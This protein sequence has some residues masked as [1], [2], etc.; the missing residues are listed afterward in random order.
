MAGN[1]VK[2]IDGTRLRHGILF[3]RSIWSSRR[4]CSG[5]QRRDELGSQVSYAF[6][7]KVRDAQLHVAYS[8]FDYH[9]GKPVDTEDANG[10]VSS[11]YYNDMLDRLTQI[12]RAVGTGVSN[13]TTF[14]YDD[15]TRIITASSDRDNFG[16]NIIVSKTLYDGLGRTTETRQYE[17][18]SNYIV[19]QQQYDA[20]NRAFKTSNPFRPWQGQTAV[21]TTQAFDALGRVIS[22][23]T[24]DNAVVRTSYSG[25]AVTVTDQAGK[26]RRV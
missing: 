19:V 17:G 20:L 13:Q 22:V 2:A 23:T 18:G 25:N 14:S 1:V 5:K 11:L 4:Q 16:D 21:W 15:D 9:L 26:K 7:T 24:P 8:Q 3:R 6:A 10:V 12:R